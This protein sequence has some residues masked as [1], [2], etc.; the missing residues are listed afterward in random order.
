MGVGTGGTAANSKAKSGLTPGQTAADAHTI[1]LEQLAIQL[2]TLPQ[3]TIQEPAPKSDPL[4]SNVFGVT[5]LVQRA[6]EFV[7]FYLRGW[8]LKM[9]T[10]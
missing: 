1:F 6:G 8:Q 2:K 10:A 4:I 5:Q 9:G 3:L 7:V